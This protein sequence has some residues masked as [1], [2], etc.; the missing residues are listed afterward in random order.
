MHPQAGQQIYS[1]GKRK[2]HRHIQGPGESKA[3]PGQRDKRSDPER[4]ERKSADTGIFKKITESSMEQ[5]SRRNP[6]MQK[7]EYNKDAVMELRKQTI[8]AE[9]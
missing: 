2:I 3:G 4:E 7:S 6:D 9:R 5:Q 1:K 8:N